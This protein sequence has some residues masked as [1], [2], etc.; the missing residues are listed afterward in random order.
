[1]NRNLSAIFLS[2]AAVCLAACQAQ[3]E[4]G[5]AHSTAAPM[6]TGIAGLTAENARVV[7]PAVPGNPAGVF[8]DLRYT[9]PDELTLRT[10]EI[11]RAGS[12][13]MHD[14]VEQDGM[15]RMAPLGPVA[16]AKGAEVSFAPGAKH[17]MAMG[18]DASVE[19][20]QNLVVKLGFGDGTSAQFPARVEA[21][22]EAGMEH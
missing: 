22:G 20:G 5:D 16:I 7:L 15:T 10:V 8:F 21:A 11:E 4:H 13:M 14:V 2:A 1:M 12:A 19:P 18:L 3:D 9:G 6:E 17:V